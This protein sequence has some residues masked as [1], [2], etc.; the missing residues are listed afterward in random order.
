MLPGQTL[1]L[2]L[3]SPMHRARETC[4]LAGLGGSTLIDGELVGRNYVKYEGL[5][6]RQIYEMAPRWLIFRDG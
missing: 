2:V 4:E 3:C 6:P 1:G 5:T